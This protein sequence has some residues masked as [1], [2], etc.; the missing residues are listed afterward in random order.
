MAGEVIRSA[1]IGE[2]YIS[3]GPSTWL[4]TL[5]RSAASQSCLPRSTASWPSAAAVSQSRLTMSR[6]YGPGVTVEVGPSGALE[7]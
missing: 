6:H 4:S 7:R 1:P 5:P 3:A 2:S